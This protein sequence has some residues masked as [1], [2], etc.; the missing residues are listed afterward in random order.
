MST[1]DT[2]FNAALG[3]V[4]KNVLEAFIQKAMMDFREKELSTNTR[5]EEGRQGLEQQRVDLGRAQLDEQKR[6]DAM[7][8]ILKISPFIN[9]G[10]LLAENAVLHDDFKTAFP[11]ADPTNLEGEGGL[12]LNRETFEN[13][14]N[15]MM[16]DQI[17]RMSPEAQKAFFTRGIN[18]AVLG[19]NLS[20]EELAL[21]DDQIQLQSQALEGLQRDPVFM[22]NVARKMF[23]IDPITRLRIDGKE[24]AFDSDLAASLSV[25]MWKQRSMLDY[26][27]TKDKSEKGTGLMDM[28]KFFSQQMADASDKKIQ[29]S[30]PVAAEIIQ[31]VDSFDPKLADDPVQQ[32]AYMSRINA[33]KARSP[34]VSAAVDMYMSASKL[35]EETAFSFLDA[36]PGLKNYIMLGNALKTEAGMDATTVAQV[37]PGLARKLATEQSAPI[38]YPRRFMFWGSNTPTKNLEGFSTERDQAEA[39]VNALRNGS[40]TTQ[41]II[42]TWGTQKARAII[43]RAQQPTQG[44]K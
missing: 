16:L 3:D 23:G 39:D 41:Q 1:R 17:K 37:L 4:G 26:Y 38:A 42:N 28:A 8:R 11:G 33:L 40:K 15:P 7:E 20:A 30:L 21:R 5:L 22:K 13:T 12:M 34:E 24:I 14:I 10:T 19:E 18:K 32:Q 31:T 36:S 9:P 29:L 27:L 43:L 2:G 35:S 6:M 25:E 44:A